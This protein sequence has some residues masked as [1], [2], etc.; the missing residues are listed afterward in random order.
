MSFE[1][2][3]QMQPTKMTKSV[4]EVVWTVPRNTL[5]PILQGR[6]IS[7]STWSK[8]FD[9]VYGHYEV[10]IHKLHQILPRRGLCSMLCK[11][12]QLVQFSRE[13]QERWLVIL[14]QEQNRYNRYGVQVTLAKEPRSHGDDSVS[15]QIVGLKFDVSAV[16]PGA[17]GKQNQEGP[18]LIAKLHELNEMRQ[19]GIITNV[20]FEQA[21]SKLLS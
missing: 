16:I 9:N 5:P 14:Q 2:K 10:G 11:M 8:T 17:T 15:Y 20:E 18:D 6:G 4:E 12:R 21:K 19:K 13:Y 3:P 1:L 7:D